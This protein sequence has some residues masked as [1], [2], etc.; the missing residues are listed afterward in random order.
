[1]TH[2]EVNSNKKFMLINNS[3]R[4]GY[5]QEAMTEALKF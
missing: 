5:K 4:V 2:D 1:M 3:D